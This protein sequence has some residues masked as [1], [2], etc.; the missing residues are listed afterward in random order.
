MPKLLI[1]IASTRPGRV[2]LPIGQ[3][4]AAESKK[5]DGFEVDVADLAEIALPLL[6]EP[7]HPR[8]GRYTHAH[9]QQ[10]AEKVGAADAFVFVTPEYN[11]AAPPSLTNAISY[12]YWEWAY[13][14]VTF[15]SYGGV[16]AG[17]RAV[18]QIKQVVAGLRMV[19]I[20]GVTIPFAPP[21]VKDGVFEANPI[22]DAT[23]PYAL[24]EVL[25][26]A[27]ALEP[28]RA[29]LDQRKKELPPG[30]PPPPPGAPRPPA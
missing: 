23:V 5:H 1:V 17:L 25:R 2:G 4:A 16:S 22:M 18:Q 11:H 29:D 8:M 24:D 30:A 28:L 27:N 10:W 3:W 14:P 12:L 26:W 15:V 7:Y 13:K 20:D 21:L 19:A 6:D 9:T